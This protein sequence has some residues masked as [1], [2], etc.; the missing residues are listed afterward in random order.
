[1]KEELLARI[2]KLSYNQ[3]KILIELLLKEKNIS[4]A[5]SNS[6]RKE[7]EK[8]YPL[9]SIQKQIWIAQT[10]DV[11]STAYT[12]MFATKI[13]GKFNLKVAQM[14]LHKIVERHEILKSQYRLFDGNPVQFIYQQE[15]VSQLIDLSNI[16]LEKGKEFV[17]EF[18]EQLKKT[19]FDLEHDRLFQVYLLQF[20]DDNFI[21]VV[22]THH[23]IFDFWSIQIFKE[24]FIK[25]YSSYIKGEDPDLKE[26]TSTYFDFAKKQINDNIVNAE[27]KNKFW[28]EYYKDVVFKCLLPTDHNVAKA[29]GKRSEQYIEGELFESL[30][31]ISSDYNTTP[32]I[33]LISAFVLLLYRYTL[34][35]DY[36]VMIPVSYRSDDNLENV[37]GC[38]LDNMP[39]RVQMDKDMSCEQIWKHVK[40]NTFSLYS[41]M[42]AEYSSIIHKMNNSSDVPN[43]M[44]NYIKSQD[45]ENSIDI[46]NLNVDDFSFGGQDSKYDLSVDVV[47]NSHN[48]WFS[49]EYD[50][51]LFYPNT[52][53]LLIK[54]YLIILHF[55][56]KNPKRRVDNLMNIMKIP[57]SNNNREEDEFDF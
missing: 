1:M 37:I 23:I 9:S 32:F 52:I 46:G 56:L 5:D 44:F 12:I 19:S 18:I 2:D 7:K 17:L 10:M 16:V 4:E 33:V 24:E 47:E 57:I 20:K 39:L 25:I 36:I 41:N 53:A 40:E 55:M 6:I 45:I 38:L 28:Q 31:D 15:F 48:L 3:Q 35:K 34:R 13:Q 26:V 50:S 27:A 42:G 21:L 14:A 30:K 8:L 51:S 43:V 54:D 29:I 22:K 49:L 11:D